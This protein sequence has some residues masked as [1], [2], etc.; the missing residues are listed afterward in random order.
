MTVILPQDALAHPDHRPAG[1]AKLP[2]NPAVPTAVAIDLPFPEFLIAFGCAV[3]LR[4]SVPEAPIDKNCDLLAPENEIGTPREGL[5]ASP[6]GDA[7]L[8]EKCDHAP[9]SRLIAFAS[10]Q[11]HDLRPLF[12]AP[13]VGH[14][15]LSVADT[16]PELLIRQPLFWAEDQPPGI[17]IDARTSATLLGSDFR[18]G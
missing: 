3:T 10:D 16:G 1:L 7:T 5:M 15:G 4:A 6:A 13:D 9:L 2:R 18:M 12:F 11:R 8:P 14:G 17:I